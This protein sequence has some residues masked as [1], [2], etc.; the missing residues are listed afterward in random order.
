MTA[1]LMVNGR[2]QFFTADGEPA[3]AGFAYYYVPGTMTF[4][5][6]WKDSAQTI[7]NTNPV[8]LD[9]AGTAIVYGAGTYRE[10]VTDS[11]GNLLQDALTAD[12]VQPSLLCTGLVLTTGA[13]VA[14]TDTF[15]QAIGKLQVQ[16][17]NF[18]SIAALRLFTA[19]PP[20]SVYVTGYTATADGGEGVFIYNS[21]DVTSAD[22]GGTIIVDAAGR[23]W[24]R[25]RNGETLNVRW[26]GAKM[27]STADSASAWNACL[28]ALPSAG[29]KIYA[30]GSYTFGSQISYTFATSS[31]SLTIQGDGSE[32]SRLTWAAGGG[33]IINY[34]SGFNSAHIRDFAFVCGNAGSGTALTLNMTVAN[35]NS[36]NSAMNDITGCTFRGADGYLLTDYFAVCVLLNGVSNVN[37]DND[38][39][40]G[41]GPVQGIGLEIVGNVNAPT[42]VYN[43]VNCNFVGLSNALIY[44]TYTQGLTV[45][46]S[47]FTDCTYGIL[48]NSSEVGL[49]QISVTNCQFAC[50]NTGIIANSAISCISVVGSLFIVGSSAY[51]I[52]ISSANAFQITGNGFVPNTTHT[53]STGIAIVANTIPGVITCNTIST[54][55]VGVQF[56]AGSTKNK[57]AL[58]IYDACTTNFSDSGTANVIGVITA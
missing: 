24:Y 44:G 29:G 18:A 32:A 27:N 38:Q 9:A 34:I 17:T 46:N 36:A 47:N 19:T 52:Y 56:G 50:N 14:S 57:L 28:A 20:A 51:G 43:V 4:K 58:N 42:V 39:F 40:S 41:S 5:Q 16:N 22:N 3:A 26:F 30:P 55:T 15:T 8:V 49:D 25:D 54:M 2:K 37:F 53:N 23:R 6:T 35:S 10:Y 31:A 21:S 13:A 48:V 45:A 1:S 7:A 33:I 12:S 11:Q